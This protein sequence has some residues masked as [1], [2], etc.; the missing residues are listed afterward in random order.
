MVGSYCSELACCMS[1]V[2]I[3]TVTQAVAGAQ[4]KLSQLCSLTV[5][6]KQLSSSHDGREMRN[7]GQEGPEVA[8]QSKS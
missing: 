7:Q 6:L 5:N 1:G 3:S 2:S 8:C 4:S